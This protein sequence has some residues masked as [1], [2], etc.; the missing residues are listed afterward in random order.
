MGFPPAEL[1]R[2]IKKPVPSVDTLTSEQAANLYESLLEAWGEEGWSRV[3][4]ICQDA[5]RK[6][7]RYSK[8]W[9]EPK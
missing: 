1:V 4:L 5:V 3:K 7:A 6:G 9:C 8:N 2:P